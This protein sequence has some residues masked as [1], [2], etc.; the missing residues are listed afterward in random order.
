MFYTNKKKTV[1]KSIE[2]SNWKIFF[3]VVKKWSKEAEYNL[4]KFYPEKNWP[5]HLTY[6]NN[7]SADL[8][9]VFTMLNDWKKKYWYQKLIKNQIVQINFCNLRLWNKIFGWTQNF[10]SPT[11]NGI[12]LPVK[13]NKKYCFV[14]STY[15]GLISGPRKG[16]VLIFFF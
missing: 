4:L 1:L 9:K 14:V 2:N 3:V 16:A 6:K 8:S 7:T 15:R 10:L 12:L 5:V 13:F 11:I